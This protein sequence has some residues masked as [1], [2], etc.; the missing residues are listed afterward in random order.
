M[1]P[2]ATYRL[3]LNAGFGFDHAAA[4]APYLAGL[5]ISH[6]YCSPYLKARP[7]STHGYDIVDHNALNPELGGEAAFDRMCAAFQ[8]HG[9]NQVLDFAPNHMGVGGADNP[10]WLDVLE[11]GQASHYAGWFDIDWAPG[12]RDLDGKLLVPVLGDQYGAALDA[13]HLALKF[14]AEAGAF[15]VWAYDAHKL[16]IDPA[17]YGQILGDGDAVLERLGDDFAAL[18]EW[19]PQVRQRADSLK[20]AL[21]NMTCDRPELAQAIAARLAAFND[22]ADGRRALDALI[23]RQHWRVAHF[24]VAG[25]DINYRRFFDI[26]D[27]AGVRVELQEVFDHM[28]ALVLRLLAEGKIDGLRID[29]IDGLLDP[30]AY[31]ERL[32]AQ[33]GGDFYLVV[34]KILAGHESLRGDWPVDGTTGYDFANLALG[35]LVDPAGEAGLTR[36][37]EAFAGVQP[38]F[39]DLVRTCKLGIMAN[40]MAGELHTLARAAARVARQTPG[41]ADFTWNILRR[42]L[43]EIVACFPVYRTYIDAAA[44][45]AAE[46]RRDL[47]WALAQARKREG[48]IDPSVF[49]FLAAVLSGDIVAKPRSGFSRHTVLRCAMKLQQYSGPVMAKGLEDTAFYRYGR[50]LAVN[51]VGGRPEQ[52]GVSVAAFHRANA[53]RAARWP[54]AMLASSTHDTKRGEDAR[55]RLAVLSEIP[56]DWGRRTQAWSRLLRA[57]LG[58][59]EGLGAPDRNDEYLFYQTLLGSWPVELLGGNEGD[60]AALA[61]YADRVKGALVKSMREAKIHSTWSA[62]NE[63]YEAAM[64]DLA[65]LALDPARSGAFL[66]DFSAFAGEIAALGARNSLA[67]TVLKL[68]APGVPDTYQ[69]AELWD[70]SLVDPDNR[71]AVDYAA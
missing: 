48:A 2:R 70:L 60:S 25:D 16:P 32:R 33:G 57:R 23:S 67:Q 40:E 59:V 41:T 38:A 15:A 64:L 12:R 51:E 5:G 50:L 52:F 55:A 26:N 19:R 45:P 42:A 4:I 11:W 34:E 61:A 43:R 1:T 21:A 47:D 28:H 46:D 14:D 22:D 31:L 63:A 24:R 13:G 8:A 66:A 10:L 27:L 56:E 65:A 62:P 69:G 37:Y 35:L 68:T 7:G 20:A 6:V 49:D 44:T 54:A 58:D 53:Q 36:A 9:L 39:A 71:R 29:H 18:P 30:K 3:Q 17:H